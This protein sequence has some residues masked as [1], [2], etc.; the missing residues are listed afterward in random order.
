MNSTPSSIEAHLRQ[1]N[2]TSLHPSLYDSG[3]LLALVETRHHADHS[4]K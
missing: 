3:E 2:E 4:H 1:A